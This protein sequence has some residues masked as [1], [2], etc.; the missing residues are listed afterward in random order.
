LYLYP[1]EFDIKYYRGDSENE[2]LEKQFSAVLTNMSINYSPMGIFNTFPN[3]MPTMI[4]CQLNFRELNVATK[5]TSPY[6]KS[7]A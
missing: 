1:S 5:E 4:T 3:G 2:Y 7:G 6:D